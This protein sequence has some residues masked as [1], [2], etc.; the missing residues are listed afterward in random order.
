MI[1]TGYEEFQRIMAEINKKKEL[2]KLRNG[3]NS[4]LD[5]LKNMFGV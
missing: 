1:M 2:E 3:D 5:F 4:S